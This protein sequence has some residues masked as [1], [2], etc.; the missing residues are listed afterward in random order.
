MELEKE[1]KAKMARIIYNSPG[2]EEK[3]ISDLK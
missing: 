2:Y 3:E 1:V